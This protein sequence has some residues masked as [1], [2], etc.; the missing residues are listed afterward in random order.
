MAIDWRQISLSD[1]QGLVEQIWKIT[2]VVDRFCDEEAPAGPW[3]PLRSLCAVGGLVLVVLIYVVAKLSVGHSLNLIV[4][5]VQ[6]LDVILYCSLFVLFVL[7]LFI[8]HNPNTSYCKCFVQG[9]KWGIW[10][11]IAILVVR[12]LLR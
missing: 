7:S 3:W 4:G 5:F 9:I 2:T 11:T 6:V 12:G 8:G 10:I 1:L